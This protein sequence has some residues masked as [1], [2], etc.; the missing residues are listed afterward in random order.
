MH[1]TH[2][3]RYAQIAS[4]FGQ[5]SDSA[6]DPSWFVAMPFSPLQDNSCKD[7]ICL[8]SHTQWSTERNVISFKV[9]QFKVRIYQHVKFAAIHTMSSP[10]YAQNPPV[11]LRTNCVKIRPIFRFGIRSTNKNRSI[12]QIIYGMLSMSAPYIKQT[13]TDSKDLSFRPLFWTVKGIYLV[14]QGID[15]NTKVQFTTLMTRSG[16]SK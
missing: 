8:N 14:F 3:F 6:S 9:N 10:G 15:L 5:Y 2:P 16:F 11:S 12:Q 13:K 4:K 7:N 1:R